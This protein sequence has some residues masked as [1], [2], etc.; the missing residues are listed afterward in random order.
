[1]NHLI[2]DREWLQ[3]KYVQEEKSCR[4]I[5]EIV[6][7]IT[8]QGVWKS[9][10]RNGIKT[11]SQKDAIFYENGNRCKVSQGYVWVYDP[12]HKKSNCGYVKRSVLVLENKLGR[13]LKRSEIPHHVDGNKLN[14]DPSNLIPTD[15][16]EHFVIH[17]LLIPRDKREED[18]SLKAKKLCGEDILE[19]RRMRKSGM[20]FREIADCFSVGRTA[21]SNAFYGICWGYIKD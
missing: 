14:D 16:S 6:G 20:T 10:K 7:G 4:E 5:A 8:R 13:K 18:H 12:D 21:V 19:I 11:R 2:N 3:E 17:H 1:M 15:R 9:L